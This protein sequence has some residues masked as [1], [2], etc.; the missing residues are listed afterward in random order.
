MLTDLKDVA[1]QICRFDRA[2]SEPFVGIRMYL[3]G[4][5]TILYCH[6]LPCPLPSFLQP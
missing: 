1:Q 4:E 2:T 5:D 3:R 6:L